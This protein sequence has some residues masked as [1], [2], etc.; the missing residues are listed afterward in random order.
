MQKGNILIAHRAQIKDNKPLKARTDHT[1]D[2]LFSREQ[3]IL[4]LSASSARC[5]LTTKYMTQNRTENKKTHFL[6][7][8]PEKLTSVFLYHVCFARLYNNR[9]CGEMKRKT[10]NRPNNRFTE[11]MSQRCLE[12]FKKWTLSPCQVNSVCFS[13]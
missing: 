9:R 13:S 5:C 12:G 8:T 11:T 7:A 1:D 10:K 4:F 2:E 3:H 6:S